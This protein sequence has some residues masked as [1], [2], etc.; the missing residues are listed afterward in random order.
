MEAFYNSGA[1][2]T[3]YACGEEVNAEWTEKMPAHLHLENSIARGA[4]VLDLGCGSAHACRHLADRDVKY[5][6]V[7]WSAHQVAINRTAYPSAAFLAS[8]LCDVAVPEGQFDAVMS[9]Y[10]IEHL[11]WPQRSPRGRSRTS[12]IAGRCLTS[13]GTCITTACHFH[14]SCGAIIRAA[15]TPAASSSTW[16]LC[17]CGEGHGFRLGAQISVHW[18]EWGYVLARKAG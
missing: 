6:G 4:R 1:T 8:S 2:A 12:F 17:V 3:Y 7:D 14:D 15:P 18:P 10:V 5:F 9:L 16:S 11:V 13:C